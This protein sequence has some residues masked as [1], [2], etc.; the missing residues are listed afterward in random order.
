[1][2]SSSALGSGFF[3]LGLWAM[4]FLGLWLLRVLGLG[5]RV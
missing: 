1:M 3:G 2:W 5:L 4:G